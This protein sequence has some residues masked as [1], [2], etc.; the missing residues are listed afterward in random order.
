MVKRWGLLICSFFLTTN[1]LANLADVLSHDTKEKTVT[2]DMGKN[3][4]ITPGT[5]LYVYKKRRVKDPKGQG[6]QIRRGKKVALVQ[7][8]EVQ[9]TKAIARIHRIHM[10]VKSLAGHVA[11]FD[12]LSLEDRVVKVNLAP[13]IQFNVGGGY[14][15]VNGFEFRRLHQIQPLPMKPKQRLAA[16]T[17]PMCPCLPLLVS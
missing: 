10:N 3:H 9:R 2:L 11:W 8:T 12:G 6:V 7:V 4:G 14:G 13:R 16:M 5:Y 1:L 17:S 15:K